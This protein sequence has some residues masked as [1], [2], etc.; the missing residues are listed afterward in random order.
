MGEA[1]FCAP[2][3]IELCS[4]GGIAECGVSVDTKASPR[5]AAIEKAQEELRQEYDVREERRRELEFLEKGGNP[6]DFKLG[7]VASLSVQSTSVTDQIAEQNVISE[8]KGS[9]AFAASPHGDS[10]ES[11]GKPGNSLCREGNTADNLM[12]LDGDTSNIGGEK[13][14]KRGT[15][16]TN[17]AQA[18]QFLHCDGQNSAKEGE[19]SGLFRLGPK[20]Q[21]YARRRSKSIRE[22]A[23]SASVRHPPI[24]PL[25]SQ[26]K[27]VAGLIPEAKTEDNGISCMGDLKPTSPNCKNMLKNASLDDNMAVETDGVQ[28]AHEGNQSSKN[29]L[30][31]IN[32]GSQAME[33]L[34]NSVTDNLPVTIGDQMAAATASVESPDAISKEDA[35]RIAC[36]MPSISNEILKEAQTPEKAGDSPY[37]LSAVDIHADGMDNKSDAP[38]SVVKSASLNENDVDPTLACATKAV[39]EHPGQN[40]NLVPVNA[41]EMVDEGLNNIL[42]EG[43]DDKKDGQLEVSSEPVALD[44]SSTPAQ[45][46]ASNSLNVNDE[47]K[48]C[49]DAGDAQTN[50]EPLATSNQEKGNKEECADSDRNNESESIDA[51]KPASVTVPPALL[52][53]N[54]TNSVENDVEKSSGD[55]EK[56][57]K[58][59]CDDSIVAKKD[60]EDAILRRARY[61]E[62]NIRRAGEQSV[63]NISL[64]KK[65]K[66]HWDFVLEEMVWMANDFMQERL[67]KSAAAAQ[68]SHWVSSSGRAAFEEASIHRKQKSV[69]KMLA[70][71]IMNFWRSVDTLR[72]SDGMPK[73]TQVEQSSELEEK[74]LG[75]VKAGKQDESLKQ[76]KSHQ[77]SIKSYALRLLEYNINTSECLSLAEAP[78]TPDRLNDFGILKV[79]DQL[80]EEN[81]FY[82]VAPG[83]V[84][85]YMRCMERLFVY[86]K[87]IGNTVLKDDY[88]PSTYASVADVPMENAYGDDEGEACTYSLPG[89]Y[90]GGLASKLSH[91]KKHL[92][93]QRMNGARP[94]EFGADMPYESVLESKPGNQQLLSN[95]K[96]TTDFLSIPIKRIRTASRQRIVSPFPAGASGTPQFTNK[97]DASSGDTNSCQDDQ[98]SLHGGSFARKNADIE[99]TVDFD[100]QLLYDG[101]EVSTK[102]KKKKKPKHPGYRTPQSGAESMV[103]GKGTYDPR[104][105]VDS[106]AQYDQK[107]YLKKRPETHQFDSNGN[108][109]VNGQHAAKKPKLTNHAQDISMEALTPVGPMASPAASQMSNMANPMKVIKIST[110]G[111]KS[112][113]LKVAAGHS[114]PGCPWSSFEDQA[115]VVLVHDMGENWEL[116]SDALNSIIQLKCIYRRPNECKERHKL[117]TDK[118]SGDGADSADDS[119]SSQHYPSALPG[120]PKGSARQLFQRLQGPFEEETLKTHFEKIIFLGQKL[121]LTCRKNVDLQKGNMFDSQVSQN[122]ACSV[123]FA[124]IQELRQ[125][126]PLHASHVF[127]LSQACPGNLSGVLL[128][129]L[130]LC[131][132]PSN[133]DSLSVSYP[134]SHTTG[135]TLPNNHGSIGP[136]SNVNCRLPGSPGMVLG[137]NSPLP[138][139]APSRDVQRYGV[140]RPTSL[141]GDDQS[142]I[143]YNQMV[144]G[145]NLQQPGVPVPGVLPSGVDRGAR[146][147][148]PAHSVGIMTGLNRG[149]PVTRPSFPRLGSPGMANAVSPGNMSPNNGQ[150]LQNTINVHPGAIPGPGNTMLRPR[151]PMQLLRRMVVK[152]LSQVD[153]PGQS[154]EEHR[155]MMMPEYQLQVSQGN[156]HAVHFS[157]PP[158]SNTGA[159]SPVQSFPIQQSQPHQMPQ[160]SHMYGNSH[161]PHTQGTNQSNTQ[162]QQAYAMRLARE[163]HIQQMMPQQQ[164]PLPGA[165][166]APTV[167]NGSQMHQQSQGSAAAVISVSQQQHKQQH[168]AQNP[169]G[170]PMLSHQPST[171]TSHKQKKQQGQQQPR[172]NQQQRNQ[173]SQQA[174]LMKSLGRGNMMPQSPVDAT[175]AS[176]ISTTCKNQVPDKNVMQQGQGHFAGSKGST[177]SIPQSGSQPKVY[178][179]QMPLSPMQAPDINNQGAVKGSSNHT[180]L[181]SQQGPLHSPSHLAT[182]QQL[183]YMNSSQNNIQRLMMQQ[184]RHMNTDGRIELPADQVQHNQVMS[185][186][187]LARSTDSGS[188]GISSISQRK[189]ESSHDPSAVTST[190]QL[191]SPPQD[192]FVASDKLLPSASQ[193]MLQRQMSGGVPIHGH[194]IGG[195]LQQQ[196]S[197]QQQQQQ[198]RPVVQGSVYAH[199]SNSGP[200]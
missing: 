101:N 146:M 164:R 66:S 124:E 107:D 40:E 14:A 53:G 64:E 27:D 185:S 174:K 9:F 182:Q 79:P 46:E 181:T 6:L 154:S 18:E 97:T 150:G 59:G 102:T 176:G 151:D 117:L 28:A 11:S 142:R 81:L 144:S 33:I 31:N 157:G 19:D 143:H 139:N 62:A 131:D 152:L 196:Q 25:S 24:P 128:T 177:P 172:P 29:E 57:A 183:R 95:G 159:S 145:R 200:G 197:R 88:E 106:F 129:P 121:H 113:G 192:T 67:W 169:L 15:K 70:N 133:S 30:S 42:P 191:A 74:K 5:R 111:R 16:R 54:V 138:L 73:P 2:V 108:F 187:S 162:Q 75:W 160:Q 90:D 89:T 153:K 149:T 186:A 43:K 194:A 10:V 71:G 94:Y 163:R 1:C 52:T 26:Q 147:M 56:I 32:N 155:Q 86:K 156:N 91:K 45:P 105:Q 103:P 98:S 21:A 72:A 118:S 38:H 60:H 126:N 76:E 99:S 171:T 82:G 93:P 20:S 125:I 130:D 161:L 35:S 77:S 83:A 158:F 166:A 140:P 4:M 167:Q 48:V 85:A 37:T 115:L 12:L 112:K 178:N 34:P 193:S 49:N 61:I 132:G 198:Q 23:N 148:S 119:G 114:G 173:G 3:A 120:I 123:G 175:Q 41:D 44:D 22:N 96:R 134:G 122:S 199:P 136:T 63:C 190:S 50:T 184:N 68:M 180:L 137:S 92:L 170:N 104:S 127:A 47:T 80:S 141:H 7:N 189:Q 17:A 8:A 168:P 100:R 55:Q 165:S 51:Q 36:S 109:V 69:A 78:P 84:Q 179:S 188:P 110:R 87:K 39:N 65:R 116:V 195:Q 58:K 13:I 135:L